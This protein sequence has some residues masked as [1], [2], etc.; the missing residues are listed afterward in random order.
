VELRGV[1]DEV[2]HHFDEPAPVAEDLRQ[3]VLD[4]EPDPALLEPRPQQLDGVVHDE[5][6]RHALRSVHHPADARQAQQLVEQPLHRVG[7]SRDPLD[8]AAQPVA[9]TLLQV[10]RQ[11]PEKPANRDQR[12]LQVVRHGVAEAFELRVLALQLADQRL[13]LALPV[14]LQ[15]VA[16]QDR[17]HGQ[18][19]GDGH[20]GER[21]LQRAEA[22]NRRG[23]DERRRQRDERGEGR[24]QG[25]AAGEQQDARE[26][27]AQHQVAEGGRR[28]VVRLAAHDQPQDDPRKHQQ[29]QHGGR[30]VAP[31]AVE[32]PG[33]EQAQVAVPRRHVARLRQDADDVHDAEDHEQ[34]AEKRGEQARLPPLGQAGC[35]AHRL[36]SRPHLA[37]TSDSTLRALSS[38]VR[39]RHPG[40]ARRR[41]TLKAVRSGRGA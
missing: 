4:D 14:P 13:A 20:H 32:Q 19:G 6:K 38:I 10:L 28:G 26:L 1:L 3:L 7:R 21:S 41:A 5:L 24:E 18:A 34:Q 22:R 31:V 40:A 30:G 16:M 2:V 23:R 17:D 37:H 33:S 29:G 35:G 25:R 8:V 27:D 9:A 12:A 39:P 36:E 11:H 15:A